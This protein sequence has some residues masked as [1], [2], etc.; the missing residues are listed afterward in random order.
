MHISQNTIV[1]I[2]FG[3]IVAAA[4]GYLL[5]EKPS[6]STTTST[7]TTTTS[8]GPASGAEATFVN[9]VSQLDSVTFDTSILS[10]PR[11]TGLQD[12]HTAI[13]PEASGRPDPFAPL[14]GL[15]P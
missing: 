12:I 14:S 8:T 2:A 9:L 15:T 6:V 13:L 4:V 1:I 5:F 7:D 11:F 3:L 10:D